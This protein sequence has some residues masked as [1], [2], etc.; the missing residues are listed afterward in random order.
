M[1]P[2]SW[3]TER[4]VHADNAVGTIRS[5]TYTLTGAEQTFA[6]PFILNTA[7]NYQERRE[8]PGGGR[9]IS[10]FTP[11]AGYMRT[12]EDALGAELAVAVLYRGFDESRPLAWHKGDGRYAPDPFANGQKRKAPD[13]GDRGEVRHSRTPWL[14]FYD[15][16][17]DPK[18][19]RKPM[20]DE[21]HRIFIRATGTWPTFSVRGWAWG[22]ELYRHENWLRRG[23]WIPGTNVRSRLEGFILGESQLHP[24]PPPPHS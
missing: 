2:S 12:S 14:F 17:G 8:L 16:D 3:Y 1:S 20:H 5:I 6:R 15:D 4:V 21:T 7:R 22:W 23:D 9:A 19:G 11:S 18:K 10:R 13:I 24:W